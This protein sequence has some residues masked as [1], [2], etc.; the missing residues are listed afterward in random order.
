MNDTKALTFTEQEQI[1]RRA[2][3]KKF[4]DDGSNIYPEVRAVYEDYLIVE[5]YDNTL[6]YYK[7]PFERT[8]DTISFSPLT[9]WAPVE[10]E[11]IAHSPPVDDGGTAFFRENVPFMDTGDKSLDDNTIAFMGDAA[12]ALGGGKVGG[13]LVLYGDASKTDLQGDYFDSDTDFVVDWDDV[14]KT[15]V[16]YQHGLDPVLKRRVI[17]TAEMKRDAVGVWLE[18]QL[19]MRDDYE[20]AIYGMVEA[21]KMGWSSGTIPWL[22]EREKI[23]GA[24]RI[25]RW[26]LGLDAS[27]TPLPT[28]WRNH[29]IPI[30]SLNPVPVNP[31]TV[32][33]D[34]DND[35]QAQPPEALE[36]AVS[37]GHEP[38]SEP[39]EDETSSTMEVTDMTEPTTQAPPA[40]HEDE[41]R[42]E[43]YDALEAKMDAFSETLNNMLDV[44]EKAPA[45]KDAGYTT[46]MGGTDDEAAKS[47][48]DWLIAVRRNDVKRLRGVYGSERRSEDPAY[49]DLGTTDGSGGGF[50][51]PQAYSLDLLQ[52]VDQGSQIL[53]RVQTV[54]VQGMPSGLYPALDNFVTPT[55]GSGETAAAAGVKARARAEGATLD[56]TEPQFVELEYRV[57]QIGGFTE[58]TNELIRWSPASVENLLRQLFVI[59]VTAKKEFQILRGNGSTQYLG[60]LTATDANIGIA[61]DTDNL[62]AFADML[63][64]TSRFKA[65]GGG[66]PV[67]LCHLGLIPDI[68]Q[69]EIGTAG[70]AVPQGVGLP[71]GLTTMPGTNIPIIYS[72]HLPQDDNSGCA[73]LA[74]LNSYLVF[75]DGSLEVAF[76]EHASFT[77]N[78]GTWRFIDYSDGMPWNKSVITLADP[79]GSYTVSPFVFLND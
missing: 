60:I 23:G 29:A 7:V 52:M 70:A 25:K 9:E 27:L 46:D 10:K 50:L 5:M 42:D 74:D 43:R 1:I 65:F 79:Q 17:D 51:I 22:V 39:N 54:P 35:L 12:K 20:C 64:I 77:S 30:K 66:T 2:F 57:K 53:Q 56:E 34:G 19:N 16:Y 73:I 69:F 63:E 44:I 45:L 48:G 41:S 33:D 8:E 72:E 62:F 3:H 11:W 6:G 67:W 55:A 32:T 26:P 78:K 14:I 61:P 36:S 21:G 13:Y 75:Q 49:K 31:V 71:S 58:V 68:G 76:S 37:A 4:H 28:E 24:K 59:S 40:E 18:A 47:F 15:D 38:E